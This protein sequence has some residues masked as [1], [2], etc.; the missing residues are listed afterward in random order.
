MPT[1]FM[2]LQFAELLRIQVEGGGNG[3]LHQMLEK[4]WSAFYLGSVAA[5]FQTICN[6][7]REDTHFYSLPPAP[8]DEAYPLMLANYPELSRVDALPADQA[9]FIAAYCTHLLLDLLWFREVLV[10]YFVEESDWG[11]FPQRRLVHH[12]LLTYLD[13][14][15][16]DSLP[17]SAADILAGAR[18]VQWLP[19]AADEELINWQEMLV[20]QL[21]PGATPQ[22]VKIYAERLQM[23]PKGFLNR[24]QDPEWIEENL[25]RNV[26]V[27]EVQANLQATVP[28]CIKIVADYLGID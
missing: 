3:R 8:D 23:S 18:P 22:T 25:L 15:A 11:D 12:I 9:V 1:P 13:K 4:E 10:P 7:P 17:D 21:Q 14:L 5:D 2:H 26:P 20:A 28:R 24:L 6:V 27:D 19:F 16:F